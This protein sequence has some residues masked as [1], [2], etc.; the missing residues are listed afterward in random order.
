MSKTE[1]VHLH[2]HSEYS[3]LDGAIRL[4]DLVEAA[5]GQAVKAVAVTEHGNL[6][7]AVE[8]YQKARIVSLYPLKET[9]VQLKAALCPMEMETICQSPDYLGCLKKVGP[10]K[11]A[12]VSYNNLEAQETGKNP[13]CR[14]LLEKKKKK[15]K[16]Y[17]Q[18]I[19]K[20]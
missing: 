19:E 10:R 4:D 15:T 5:A 14:L 18:N 3:L 11:I 16:T 13:E 9:P 8:F 12:A 1:F 20:D 6:Y 7:S 2:V 17:T